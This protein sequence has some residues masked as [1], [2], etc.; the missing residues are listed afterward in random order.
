MIKS[1]IEPDET[2]EMFIANSTIEGGLVGGLIGTVV[3]L[4]IPGLGP[5][6]G[7]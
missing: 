7:Y 5:V 6:N 4:F 2:T 3:A 1:A